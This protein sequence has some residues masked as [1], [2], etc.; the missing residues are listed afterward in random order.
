MADS[1]VRNRVTDLLGSVMTILMRIC[2]S[3]Q[4]WLELRSTSLA[5]PFD[6]VA[7]PTRATTPERRLTKLPFRVATRTVE[8]STADWWGFAA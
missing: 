7:G 8:R 1:E 5:P 4:Y 2:S 6:G 3:L